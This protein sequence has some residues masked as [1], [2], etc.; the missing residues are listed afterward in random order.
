MRRELVLQ[1]AGA[2]IVQPG[3]PIET[4]PALELHLGR[5]PAD[6][7]LPDTGRALRGIDEQVPQVAD[8]R[9]P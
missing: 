6:Q 5:Q 7:P 2:V 8:R 4:R 9:E 3:M 1:A